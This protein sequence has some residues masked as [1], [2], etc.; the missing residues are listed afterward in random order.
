MAEAAVKCPNYEINLQMCPC[1]E[2]SC[3]RRGICCECTQYHV[4]STQWPLSACMRGIKRPA[5][6]LS[7][8]KEVPADCPNRERTIEVCACTY[9]PCDRRGYCCVCVRNH[10]T[11]DGTGLTACF[12]D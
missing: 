10:W 7:L 8:S 5:G 4:N 3:D 1:T 6:T 2:T 12:R 11:E 9:E